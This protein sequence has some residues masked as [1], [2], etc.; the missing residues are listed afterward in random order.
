MQFKDVKYLL[1]YLTPLFGWI[2]IMGDGWVCYSILIFTFVIV[3]IADQL[4]PQSLFN[5]SADQEPEREK[6]RI[7][8]WLLYLNLPMMYTLLGLYFYRL[9][10]DIL[11]TAELVGISLSMGIALGTMGINVGHE[12]GHRP[13]LWDQWV[14]RLLLLPSLYMHFNIEHNR[15]HHK[16]VATPF[17]PATA[18]RGQH[19]YSFFLQS[20]IG[21]YI[22][23]WKIQRQDLRLMEESFWSFKNK[24]LIFQVI[25]GLYLAVVFYLGGF[26]LVLMAIIAAIGGFGLLELVNYIE[27]YG[28]ERHKVDNGRYE[29]V[30]VHH[31]WNSNH[32]FGRILLYELTRHSDHHYKATRK[33]QVLRHFDESPQLSFGYPGSILLALAPPLWFAHMN[34]LLEVHH[35]RYAT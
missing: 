1:A 2:S 3:P 33:Y 27:H 21:G 23:A 16:W 35:K 4:L 30:E 25:Q 29:P 31:S 34:R 17:D 24:M 28:L 13:G 11:S 18:K 32:E 26:F 10:Y 14:S 7:F 15:G 19:F 5:F 8:D 22:D 12:I 6:T 9:N 20:T